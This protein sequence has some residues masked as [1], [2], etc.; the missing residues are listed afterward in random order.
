MFDLFKKT[1]E[2]VIDGNNSHETA[3]DIVKIMTEYGDITNVELDK[4]LVD[5]RTNKPVGTVHCIYIKT[6]ESKFKKFQKL[7]NDAG[8][9]ITKIRGV[10]FM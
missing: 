4:N 7:M 9:D 8:H 1:Y 6:T 3:Y 5:T 2:L 10:Y